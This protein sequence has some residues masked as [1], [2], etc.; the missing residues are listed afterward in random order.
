MWLWLEPWFTA[1]YVDTSLRPH[2]PWELLHCSMPTTLW[3][4]VFPCPSPSDYSLFEAAVLRITL[5]NTSTLR[6]GNHKGGRVTRS[7]R[8]GNQDCSSSAPG[9]WAVLIYL[10]PQKV[11][12]LKECSSSPP[13]P[14]LNSFIPFSVGVPRLL[15]HTPSL[16]ALS[17]SVQIS[18]LSRFCF[19]FQ[20]SA[21]FGFSWDSQK[22]ATFK[23]PLLDGLDWPGTQWDSSKGE[24]KALSHGQNIFWLFLSET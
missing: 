5:S 9:L 10:D 4:R 14:R 6:A 18:F 17:N 12:Q 3:G 24:D 22:P 23:A 2:C 15:F 1:Q 21:W 19:C 11:I 7:A 13:G 16:W 8:I 20:L